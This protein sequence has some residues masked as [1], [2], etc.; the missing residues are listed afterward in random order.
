MTSWTHKAYDINV[1][2][3]KNLTLK[4]WNED[5]FRLILPTDISNHS[6][7][8]VHA[9]LSHPLKK[10]RW[11]HH[12]PLTLKQAC[13]E[14]ELMR[15]LPTSQTDKT[16][17]I[18]SYVIPKPC[19]IMYDFMPATHYMEVDKNGFAT[20]YNYK[21]KEPYHPS[22]I[23]MP[24]YKKLPIGRMYSPYGQTNNPYYADK[25]LWNI[26]IQY[27][28]N[29]PGDIWNQW[30]FAVETIAKKHGFE[31]K[32]NAGKVYFKHKGR[33]VKF[34]SS[35]ISNGVLACYINISSTYNKAYDFYKPSKEKDVRD[36]YAYGLNFLKPTSSDFVV[37]CIKKFSKMANLP[38]SNKTYS[39]HEVVKWKTIEKLHENLSWKLTGKRNDASWFAE[40]KVD[41]FEH[42]WKLY[43]KPSSNTF[44]FKIKS[45]DLDFFYQP[46]LT[47]EEILQG[48]QRAP[49]VVG[50][51]AVYHKTKVNDDYQAGK[52][53][54]IYR[55]IAKDAAGLSYFCDLRIENDLMEIKV[56]EEFLD[57]AAYPVII[58]PTFG[59]NV[60]GA[61]TLSMGAANYWVSTR[62]LPTG[63]NIANNTTVT[64]SPSASQ[65][66]H[67]I[68]WAGN[69]VTTISNPVSIQTVC[70]V[71]TTGAANTAYSPTETFTYSTSGQGMIWNIHQMI[72]PALV[73]AANTYDLVVWSKVVTGT[74][75]GYNIAY[76]TNANFAANTGAVG[77]ATLS[78]PPP[79]RLAGT[80]NKNV[81]SI[82]A[83]TNQWGSNNLGTLGVG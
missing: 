37:E 41:G 72:T 2:L 31:T 16:L 11:V 5:F 18:S 67:K 7:Y 38:I 39:G 56:P 77:T 53:F 68:A 20:D 35:A 14:Y 80:G 15:T 4:K 17:I 82:Y 3:G 24:Q 36:K 54:H 30:N 23:P 43:K 49:N 65:I 47:E 78:D 25:G 40:P 26:D 21:I 12:G 57:K 58:D 33:W 45:S 59:Y 60:I 42:E 75:I 10:I 51:Y 64:N 46:E 62:R 6:F 8:P 55:P 73:I 81:Y 1:K 63:N 76:D 9:P 44:S 52:M 28:H 27:A 29:Q 71:N 13:A 22:D 50:S 70:Y 66:L 48:Y 61:S 79:T 32:K 83:I 19:I 69:I 74:Y 34:A